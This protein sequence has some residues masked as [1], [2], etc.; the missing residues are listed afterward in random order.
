MPHKIAAKKSN[1]LVMHLHFM[2][3]KFD[4][5]N[6]ARR[7]LSLNSPIFSL[8]LL[9]WVWYG[10]PILFFGKGSPVSTCIL[11]SHVWPRDHVFME[12]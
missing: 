6:P 12:C 7:F 5:M 10:V 4:M 2:D 8:N 3:K 9:L 11:E 1:L